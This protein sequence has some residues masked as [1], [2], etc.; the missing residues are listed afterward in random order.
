[1]GFAMSDSNPTDI[2]FG[3]SPTQ[4]QSLGLVLFGIGFF[5]LILYFAEDVTLNNALW[6]V[7]FVFTGGIMIGYGSAKHNPD[8]W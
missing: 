8:G 2:P 7:L 1:M 5:S 6:I 4:L 3:L